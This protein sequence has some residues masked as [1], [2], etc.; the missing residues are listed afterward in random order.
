MAPV[1]ERAWCIVRIAGLDEEVLA[2]FHRDYTHITKEQVAFCGV[3][4][5]AAEIAAGKIAAAAVARQPVDRVH[6]IHRE[7]G[8]RDC[9]DL[10]I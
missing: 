6:G 1:P 4:C 8:M 2:A 7:R 10:L 3:A 9:S 5:V